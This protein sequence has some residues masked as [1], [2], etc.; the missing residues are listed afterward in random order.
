MFE[1]PGLNR[2][3]TVGLVLALAAVPFGRHSS[4]SAWNGS[5]ADQAKI[6]RF[7][8]IGDS[9]TGKEPQYRVAEQILDRHRRVGLDFVLML[10]DNIYGHGS[11]G[12]YVKKFEQPY[13]PL[14]SDGVE[15]YAALGNHDVRWGNWKHAIDYRHFNMG[16][17]RYYTFRFGEDLAQFFALDSTTLSKGRYGNSHDPDQE[18]WL[19]KE[20]EASPA[21]WRIAFFHHPVYSSGRRHGG[22]KSVRRAV[23]RRLVEGQAR[24]VFSGHDHFYERL[25]PQ[26]G[27]LYFVNGAAAK[28]R[29]GNISKK[30]KLTRCGNDRERSFLYIELDSQEL[31]FEAVSELGH[32]FDKGTVAYHPESGLQ[33]SANCQTP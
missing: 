28:L 10:G 1:A 21:R 27:I 18:E 26:Q 24:V 32:V 12:G 8:V 25:Q 33:I 17:R 16:G 2:I 3:R 9:G 22:N 5:S 15:F 13:Q 29:K 4:S 14:I 6:L 7:A 30:S 23:E 20:L 31:R 11:R 19:G